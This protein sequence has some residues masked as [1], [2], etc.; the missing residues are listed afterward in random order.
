MCLRHKYLHN[1]M[2]IQKENKMKLDLILVTVGIKQAYRIKKI[3]SL[4]NQGV[5]LNTKL[6]A[7]CQK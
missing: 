7:Q 2:G 1:Q 5:N 3:C 4:M 6:E